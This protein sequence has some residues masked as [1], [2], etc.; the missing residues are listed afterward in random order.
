MAPRVAGPAR[1]PRWGSVLAVCA[2]PDDESFR[3][4]AVLHGLAGAGTRVSVL[5]LTAGEASTLRAG[6]VELRRVR[7]AET[8][9]AAR[10]LGLAH[11]VVLDFPDGAP[12]RQSLDRLA[13]AVTEVTEQVGA[14]ALLVFDEGGVTGH[15]DHHRATQAAVAAAE[16]AGLPVLAWAIPAAVAAALNEEHGG[17]FSG[18]RPDEIDLRLPVD[19]RAQRR[20]IAAHASQAVPGSVLWRRLELLGDVEHLRWLRP[21]AA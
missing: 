8:T 13:R 21:P 19:R 5:S 18:R 11:V 15:P 12:P 9:A 4:G 20:A 14:Q 3:L 6:L 10:A 7:A 2:H 17:R 16:P 1:L